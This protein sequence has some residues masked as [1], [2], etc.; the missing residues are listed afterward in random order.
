[1]SLP[2]DPLPLGA[3]FV[4]GQ[5]VVQALRAAPE[6]VG[7]TILDNPARATDLAEGDRVVWFEDQADRLRGQPGQNAQRTYAFALGVIARTQQARQQS[8]TDYRAAK[9]ICRACVRDLTAAGVAV[10]GFGLQE[11]EVSYRIEN[12]D[13]GGALVLGTFFVDYRDKGG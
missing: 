10:E 1:M 7:A 5:A 12:I 13:V 9:R 8:H 11:G 6:L 3:P 2:T 4:I